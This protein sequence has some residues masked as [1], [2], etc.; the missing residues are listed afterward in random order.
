MREGLYP[1]KGKWEE[2]RGHSMAEDP[3]SVV[4]DYDAA[5]NAHDVEGVMA[6][7]TDDAVVRMEPPPPDEFGGV[8]TGKEQIRAGWVEPLISGFHV[9]TSDHQVAGHQEGVG[10][11]VIWTA[12]VSGDFFRQMGAEPP[13]KSSAEAIV[14]GGKIRAF[15]AINAEPPEEEAPSSS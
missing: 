2:R 5:W 13:V 7:F 11:R 4:K 12:M 3:V 10:D 9:E 15:T 14:R 1:A 6:F 8:Y